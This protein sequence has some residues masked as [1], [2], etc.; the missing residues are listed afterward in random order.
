MRFSHPMV[1]IVGML[2]IVA[3]FVLV[4]LQKAWRAASWPRERRRRERWSKAVARVESWTQITERGDYRLVLEVAPV[5][6]PPTYRS[7]PERVKLRGIARLPR[8]AVEWMEKA[9]ELPVRVG[10]A[11]ELVVDLGEIVAEDAEAIARTAYAETGT[12]AWT[13][14]PADAAQ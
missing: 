4:A 2:A 8:E 5:D 14:V 3:F 7:T 12:P 9:N 6:A 13:T 1:W 10:R 11:S